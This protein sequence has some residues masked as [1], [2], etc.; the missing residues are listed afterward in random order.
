MLHNSKIFFFHGFVTWAL[1]IYFYLF[2]KKIFA[3]T[4]AY[5]CII[6]PI[7]AR[8]TSKTLTFEIGST[9]WI[10]SLSM[11]ILSTIFLG[12]TCSGASSSSAP[13]DNEAGTLR[14]RAYRTEHER[15]ADP[16][17]A[18]P[19]ASAAQV[20]TSSDLKEELMLL[21]KYFLLKK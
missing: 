8:W 19:P 11:S 14:A 21:T 2:K 17:P 20:N 7:K 3:D 18:A 5:M 9:A 13:G 10:S 4:R 12:T 15:R 6:T 16:R 1:I